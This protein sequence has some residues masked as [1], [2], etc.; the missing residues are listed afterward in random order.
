MEVL[1]KLMEEARSLLKDMSRTQQVGVLV[2][3]ISVTAMFASI[4]AVGSRSKDIG[5][6]P[7]PLEVE[8]SDVKEMQE[9]LSAGGIEPTVYKEDRIWVPMHQE[10]DAVLLLAEQNMLPSD[11]QPM[12]DEMLKRWSFDVTKGKSDAMMLLARQNAMARMIEKLEP[13]KEANV[14]YSGAERKYLFGPKNRERAAVKVTT[15]LGKEL[16][17]STAD[18]IV[19]LVTAAKSGLEE[20]DVVV[21]DQHGR[22]FRSRDDNSLYERAM[23]QLGLESTRRE[24]LGDRVERLCLA[25]VPGCQAWGFVDV[26]MNM[27][28]IKRHKEDYEDGPKL[29]A[30]SDKTEE[31]H[32][33]EPPA[34]VGTR[35][36]IGRASNMGSTGMT[37][38]ST[39]S[40][41]KSDVTYQNDVEITDTTVA[42]QVEHIT[43]SAIVQLPYKYVQEKDEQGNP[44]E[45]QYVIVKDHNGDPVYDEQGRPVRKRVPDPDKEL[46]GEEL[47]KLEKQIELAVGRL[48]GAEGVEIDILQVPYPESQEWVEGPEPKSAAMMRWA[49]QHWATVLMFMALIFVFYFAYTQANQALPSEEIDLDDEEGVALTM[50]PKMSEA[51]QANANFEAMRNKLGDMISENPQKSAQLVRKWMTRESY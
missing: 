10:Q 47:A 4:V 31:Q 11:A 46:Q 50:M 34:E 33:K 2:L 48:S 35:P 9:L 19:A 37:E 16:D 5:N 18:T 29:R 20:K 49:Q 44:I 38:R 41:K 32:V 14:I 36:N 21:T 1:R 30:R 25:A 27:D 13:V 51:D 43:V 28:Q 17:Q 45:G 7:L 26:R 42:P 3:V 39:R 23:K 6:V 40:Q 22:H 12:F 15:K 8:A 24:E